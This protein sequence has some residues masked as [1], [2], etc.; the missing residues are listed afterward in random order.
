MT[1][2]QQKIRAI[3]WMIIHYSKTAQE[4]FNIYNDIVDAYTVYDFY[5]ERVSR[6]EA[7]LD[8]ELF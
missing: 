3:A 2:H 6:Y 5:M 4:A 7:M 1:N 8:K